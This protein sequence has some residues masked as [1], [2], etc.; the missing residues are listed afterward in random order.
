[1][2]ECWIIDLVVLP[3]WRLTRR[4]PRLVFLS[5]LEDMRMRGNAKDNKCGGW[6]RDEV[7]L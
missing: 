2:E 3:R 7:L 4:L 1:L 5:A 6:M